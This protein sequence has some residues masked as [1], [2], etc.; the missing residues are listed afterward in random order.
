MIETEPHPSNMIVLGPENFEEFPSTHV[1]AN[2]SS[3][4]SSSDLDIS[5]SVL[6]DQN[7]PKYK[8][9][10]AKSKKQTNKS[11]NKNYQPRIE[12]KENTE[13]KIHKSSKVGKCIV[14]LQW[15]NK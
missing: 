14:S 2:S 6:S 7:S 9:K 1:E 8:K 15:Q 3:E 4:G 5:K 12:G 13:V 10:H 11:A